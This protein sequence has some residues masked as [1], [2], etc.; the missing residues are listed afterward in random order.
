MFVSCRTYVSLEYQFPEGIMKT[1]DDLY[2]KRRL[3][4]TRS[5]DGSVPYDS[6]LAD[7]ICALIDANVTDSSEEVA[8]F[9]YS[10]LF[11][12]SFY[13]CFTQ[14]SLCAGY[15]LFDVNCAPYICGFIL[16]LS[17]LDSIPMCILLLLC[18]TFM[19][20]HL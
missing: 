13:G 11:V 6:T 20:H 19:Y 3:G 7:Y 15:F 1:G 2:I 16:F 18:T 9:Q 17:L 4:E 14:S 10:R 5:S 8:L 12:W